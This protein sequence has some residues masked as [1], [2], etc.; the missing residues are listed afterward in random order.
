LAPGVATVSGRAIIVGAGIAGLTAGFRLQQAGYTVKVIE[1]E[2]LVG[3]R[4]STISMN[5]YVLDRGAGTV[6]TRYR[7]M[8][9]LV[10]EVGSGDELVAYSNQIGFVRDG[11]VHRLRS[12]TPR[13]A[14]STRLPGIRSKLLAA[15]LFLDARKFSA[16]LDYSDL[17]T[18]SGVDT[19]TVRAYADRRLTPE[20]RD[21]L[22][23]PT[24]RFLY[25]GE[26]DEYASTELF[27]LILTYLGGQMMNARSGIDFLARALAARLDVRLGCRVTCVEEDARGVTIT[28]S[29]ADTGEVV[30][31]ADAC[32]I[33]STAQQM[34]AAYPQLGAERRAIVDTLVY[35]DLWKVA[36]GVD[37]APRETAT[38]IQDPQ[39]RGPR[40]HRSHLRAQQGPGTGAG[41]Q[42][43]VECL[44]H[45]PMVSTTRRRRRRAGR[46]IDRATPGSPRPGCAEQRRVCPRDALASRPAD[47]QSRDLDQPCPV[48]RPD[49]RDR[50]SP[51]R[52]RLHRRNE[53]KLGACVGTARRGDPRECTPHPRWGMERK[54]QCST[55]MC[56]VPRFTAMVTRGRTVCRSPNTHVCGT[57]RRA[58]ATSSTIR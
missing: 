23:D 36:L 58:I 45:A 8:L 33:S 51:V 24:L 54:S 48:P 53:H 13:E 7:E 12:G 47:G 30:E 18:L 32:V 37:P 19:E 2:P 29:N 5:G 35:N 3:G 43:P 52:R 27:Y 20:L 11:K 16:R 50:P 26:L 1:A 21:Y 15:R 17:S 10:A 38:F 22:I 31:Q 57:R 42:R 6:T 34:A 4:M 56:S 41:R 14:L 49:T 55:L 44:C 25:G 40:H 28:W 9:S 39:R 46:R